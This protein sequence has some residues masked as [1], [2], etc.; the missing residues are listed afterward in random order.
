MDYRFPRKEHLRRTREIERLLSE[1]SSKYFEPYR[2]VWMSF[3][4]SQETPVKTAILV[5]KRKISKAS[6]RNKVK[7]RIREVYRKNK[8]IIRLPVKDNNRSVHLLIMYTGR[9]VPSYRETEKSLTRALELWKS[10]YEKNI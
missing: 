1:G 9:E 4:G 6:D 3:E 8:M 2:F 10:N 5:P 7:R